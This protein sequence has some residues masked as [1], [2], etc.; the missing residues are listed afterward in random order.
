MRWTH[1]FAVAMTVLAVAC[2]ETADAPQGD[3]AK[4]ELTKGVAN[5]PGPT[6]N[7]AAVST[8]AFCGEHGV[9]EAVCTKCN[10]KLVAVFKAKG[11]WCAEHEFPESFCPICHPE[12][13]GRPAVAVTGEEGPADGL[14]IRLRTRETARQAGIETAPATRSSDGASVVAVAQIAYDATR[15]ARI[16]ARAAGVVREIH[17]D[18]GSRV[19]RGSP[20]AVIESAAVG[21]DQAKL[22][23]LQAHLAVAESNFE[24]TKDLEERGIIPRKD[25]LDS[26]H[27][28]AAARADLEATQK[29]LHLVDTK[30]T[31]G[32]YVLQ[33]PF[34]G[35]VTQ[36]TTNI[37]MLVDPDDMLF[38][39]VDASWLWV[40]IQVRE[41]DVAAVRVGQTVLVTL[42][43]TSEAREAS[44]QIE[45]VAPALDPRTR[46][47]LARARLANPDGALRANMYGRARILTDAATM[48]VVVP[49]DAL[50]QARGIPV[51][52]VKLSDTLFETRRVRVGLR[53]GDLVTIAS[54]VRADELVVTQGSFLLKTEILKE[55]I[56][57]GC[58]EIEEK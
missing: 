29:S 45:Y 33:A 47:V 10:P 41:A 38:E 26:Q 23:A 3:V 2:R 49:R 24:R 39:V 16:N 36:R 31:D 1:G 15:V 5:S 18:L 53:H 14:K 32:S 56:G 22:L 55:S 42:E 58:C 21:A 12:Q 30:G 20:L 27:E 34:A 51:V 35:A 50:Q 11:D 9:L 52:F 25:V 57:A 37:G 28:L 44:G 43:G 8:D 17:V 48:S 46:T 40:E 54:G 6:A 19:Q 13:G 7:A 4:P